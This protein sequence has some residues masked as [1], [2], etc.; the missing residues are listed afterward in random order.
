MQD[1]LSPDE[2]GRTAISFF[3]FGRS[4]TAAAAAATVVST[5]KTLFPIMLSSIFLITTI[6]DFRILKLCAS[7]SSTDYSMNHAVSIL[8]S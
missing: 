3:L 5:L 4:H 8:S 7:D 6:H 1:I 2:M